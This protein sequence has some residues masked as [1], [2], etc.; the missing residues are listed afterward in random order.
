[1]KI[2]R[3]ASRKNPAANFEEEIIMADFCRQC[4]EEHFGAKYADQNDMRGATT[5][6]DFA[7]GKAVVV[8]CE[9]CGGIQVD[10]DGNC[11]THEGHRNDL[12]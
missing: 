9:G 11:L 5:Q 7:D 2:T 10:P 8:L 1:L 6:Q 4:T 12:P 3:D